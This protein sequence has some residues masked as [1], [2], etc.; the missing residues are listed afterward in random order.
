MLYAQVVR[1]LTPTRSALLLVPMA[2]LS[3]ALAPVAG[4]LTDRI[5]PRTIT[6]FELA[7][8]SASLF[9]LSRVTTVDSRPGCCCSRWP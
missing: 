5:H 3:A 4:K 1:G 8:C 7:L 9:W 6:A 2:V